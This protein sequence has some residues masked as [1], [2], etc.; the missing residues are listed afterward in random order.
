M[1]LTASLSWRAMLATYREGAV[2]AGSSAGA[3]ALCE[4]YYNP[5]AEKVEK[6]LNLIP[7]TCLIPHHNTF[8]RTWATHLARTLPDILLIGIDEETAS[9]A[10]LEYRSSED[11]LVRSIILVGMAIVFTSLIVVAFLVSLLRHLQFFERRSKADNGSRSVPSVVGT[12][13]SSGDLSDYSIAAVV[14][15]IFLHEE[16]VDAENRLLL[17]WRRSTGSAWRTGGLMPNS[18]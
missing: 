8:G 10:V 14:A 13:T 4:H 6:G 5:T 12:I 17:T 15:T 9:K 18:A 3:M 2:I 16:E 7:G 1:L 11:R